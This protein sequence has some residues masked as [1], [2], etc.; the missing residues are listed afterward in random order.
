[1]I[2]NLK[3]LITI[4]LLFCLVFAIPTAYVLVELERQTIHH[5]VKE[6]MEKGIDKQDL[7]LLQ[8]SVEDAH[9]VLQWKH[10]KEFEYR[11]RMYDVV[12][13]RIEKD[14]VFYWCWKDD[15]ESKLNQKLDGLVRL[16]L[17][18]RQERRN[19]QPQLFDWAKKWDV[20]QIAVQLIPYNRVKNV[21][22]RYTCT[23]QNN[24]SSPPT[25]PPQVG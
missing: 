9:K 15:K 6:R 22:T 3:K 20:H 12:E 4:A 1:M 16:G 21:Y 8:F 14:S 10:S 19:E 23:L 2:G 18:R 25:P 5:E 17:Q 13:K 11:N 7:V 24:H